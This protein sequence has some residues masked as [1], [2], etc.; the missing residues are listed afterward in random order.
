[1]PCVL[2]ASN[3]EAVKVFLKG[4]IKF[5]DIPKVIEKILGLHRGIKQPG[6]DEIL[7]IDNWVRAKTR[8]ILS[9]IS[10]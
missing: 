9:A 3:E 4:R 6:L 10:D 1:Y 5:T 7:D 8:E 2:N